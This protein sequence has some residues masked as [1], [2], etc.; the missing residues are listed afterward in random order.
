MAISASRPTFP[1]LFS[2]F[3]I[4]DVQLRNRIVMLPMGSRQ[5]R[6]GVPSAGDI[7]YYRARARGGVG[8]IISGG[9]VVHQTSML[10]ARHMFEAFNPSAVAGF[11][12]L[13]EAVHREGAKIF[14]QLFHRGRE[15]LGDLTWPTWAPSAIPSPVDP[16]IPHEMT[17]EEIGEIIEAFAT[18]AANLCEA[19][20]DGV[21][22]HAAHG[23][24]V[25][26]FLSPAS[27][28]R[29]D[30]FGGSLANR[31]RFLTAIIERIR[32][33]CGE[34][35]VLGVRLSADEGIEDGL[36][37]P[38]T[39]AIATMLRDTSRVDYLSVTS[40][41]K[42][43][44]VR[45]MSSPVGA[46]ANLAKEVRR[47]SGMVV[48]AAQRITHPTLA[49]KLLAEGSADLIGLARALLA[50]SDWA[51]KASEGR[52]DEIR[53]CV[54]CVQD[55]RGS[56]TR[57]L[58][59]PQ[60][61]RELVWPTDIDPQRA[62]MRRVVVVGGGPAGMEAAMVAAAR[63]HRVVLF[64]RH[65]LL[66]GQV[67]IAAQ[68]PTRTELDGVISFREAE[69]A[70]LKVEVRL[71]MA[72][73]VESVVAERPDCIV[74]ATGAKPRKSAIPGADLAHVIDVY[75]LLEGT[76]TS[77]LS[78]GAAAAVIDDG[79][80]FWETCSAAEYLSEGGLQ[81]HLITSARS[82]GEAI[83]AEAI[84][85]LLGRLRKRGV[86]FHTLTSVAAIEPGRV[87]TFDTVRL[88]ATRTLDEQS[89]PADIVVVYA[90]KVADDALLS[91][92][93]RRGHETL[94]IGDCVEPRRISHAVLEGHTAG[95]AI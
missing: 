34:G 41:I 2:P 50:D 82:I 36:T 91:E 23:Y 20:Y 39:K 75:G 6:E 30:E 62:K 43:T 85:P 42:G 81:V 78:R 7:A 66:G 32:Q 4:R 11:R 28:R 71:G 89:I 90:G 61:G 13:A 9:T 65:S 57:C 29:T 45:D 86:T 63:G 21:E 46:T 55:C 52:L 92:L 69:L 18:S 8:L 64:E 35:P 16:Q 93:R 15:T 47:A 25:A 17:P 70:R 73:S 33:R 24:L 5:A 40:G 95:R 56:S 54:A 88:A 59:N 22:V 14:G 48:I 68:A 60:T 19:G 53:P 38:D 1:I 80:G 37:L 31:M 44:Y 12:D 87:I 84:G 3:L 72:A 51:R 76:Q 83:P 77:R 58:H 26:Q 74:L 49:E 27:N 94:P 67:R 79:S 10:P